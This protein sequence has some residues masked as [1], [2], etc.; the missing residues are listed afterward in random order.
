MRL[1]KK[2]EW[3]KSDVELRR[4]SVGVRKKKNNR[5]GGKGSITRERVDGREEKRTAR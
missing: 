4:E 5:E 3:A 2:R 1:E